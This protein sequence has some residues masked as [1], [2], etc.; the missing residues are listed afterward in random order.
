MLQIEHIV[1]L[2]CQTFS[3]STPHPQK[4]LIYVMNVILKTRIFSLFTSSASEMCCCE[5]F[6]KDCLF[7]FK[8]GHINYITGFCHDDAASFIIG[9]AIGLPFL[10]DKRNVA[11][12]SESLWN[13]FMSQLGETENPEELAESIYSVYPDMYSSDNHTRTLAASKCCTE[14]WYGSGSNL[15]AVLHRRWVE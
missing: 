14:W 11:E 13:Y 8:G 6:S 9:N 1:N 7:A 3:T 5:T 15:E 10:Y 4:T 2:K 12:T